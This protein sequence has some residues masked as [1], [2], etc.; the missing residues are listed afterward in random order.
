MTRTEETSA[1]VALLGCLGFPLL[2]WMGAWIWVLRIYDVALPMAI[3]GGIILGLLIGGGVAALSGR[4][5][6]ENGCTTIPILV[7]FLIMAPVFKQA[8]DKARARTGQ[9]KALKLSPTP[10]PGPALLVRK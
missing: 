6:V 8:R 5:V 4:K 7:M 10:T 1:N 9:T 3:S 2:G